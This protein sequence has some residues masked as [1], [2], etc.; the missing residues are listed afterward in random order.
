MMGRSGA[1]GVEPLLEHA[2]AMMLLLELLADP[3]R[4]KQA[5]KSL[6]DASKEY[7]ESKAAAEDIE[8]RTSEFDAAQQSQETALRKRETELKAREDAFT[9]LEDA[10]E[11]REDA[12]TA[13]EA[14]IR[15]ALA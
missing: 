8:R 13:R 9:K 7:R 3:E 5:V 15:A 2:T 14:K 4:L 1:P 6:G 10:L 12:V 11:K